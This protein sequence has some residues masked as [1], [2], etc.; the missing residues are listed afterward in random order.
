[1]GRFGA[2]FSVEFYFFVGIYVLN[3]MQSR[4]A[5]KQAIRSET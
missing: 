1:M 5:K 2:Y 4:E 3:Y